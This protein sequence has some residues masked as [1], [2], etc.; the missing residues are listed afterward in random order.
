MDSNNSEVTK[1]LIS[2]LKTSKMVIRGKDYISRV[3]RFE[4][5]FKN[6]PEFIKWNL[7]I[8]GKLSR[9]I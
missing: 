2:R 9:L 5:V 3:F 7:F 6:S 8:F 4:E 1:T